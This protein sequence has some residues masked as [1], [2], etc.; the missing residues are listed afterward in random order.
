MN[1]DAFRDL[2]QQG[3]KTTKEIAREAVEKEFQFKKKR[4]RRG[5]A[6]SGDVDSSDDDDG[7]KNDKDRNKRNKAAQQEQ[8]SHP[9]DNDDQQRTTH[10][11]NNNNS[12][13]RDRARERRE[14]KADVDFAPLTAEGVDA[15]MSKYLGGVEAHTHLV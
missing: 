6:S 9:Y 5:G 8:Q 14:G 12:K 1:N 4:R 11:D 2:V 15:E 3:G 13:Y 10:P 7:D